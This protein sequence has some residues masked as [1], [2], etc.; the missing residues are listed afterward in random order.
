MGVSHLLLFHRNTSRMSL[1]LEMGRKVCPMHLLGGPPC[2][3]LHLPPGRVCPTELVAQLARQRGVL[4]TLPHSWEPAFAQDVAPQSWA[5]DHLVPQIRITGLGWTPSLPQ[6]WC[7]DGWRKCGGAL[8][9]LPEEGGA[10]STLQ[11]SLP[12]SFSLSVTPLSCSNAPEHRH[13]WLWDP[14]SHRLF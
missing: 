1:P 9:E 5:C 14:K 4:L 6:H 13:R 11:T 7:E 12:P 3:L 8:C 2:P 10:S